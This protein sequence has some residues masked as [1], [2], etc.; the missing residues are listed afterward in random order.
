MEQTGQNRSQWNESDNKADDPRPFGMLRDRL[1]R[2]LTDL[3]ISVTDRCNF[4][5]TYCMPREVFGSNFAFLPHQ[6][7]LTF[8]EITR[9]AAIFAAHGVRKIRL[10]GGEPLLRKDLTKL[11]A[12]LAQ[13]EGLEDLALTTNGSL[14]SPANARALK[15][16]GLQRVTISLD[17]LDDEVF[18]AMND[19]RFPVSKVLH[20]IE[21][22]HDA[23]LTPVKVNMVVKKGV[24][25]QSILAMADYFRETGHVLRFIEFMDVGTTNGW[26][27]DQV[28]SAAQ[29]LATLE[30]HWPL[31]PMDP[32]P[33]QVAT[34]Y[35]YKDGKGEIGIIASVTKAF[36]SDCSRARISSEG[37]LYTCLFGARGHDFREQLRSQ[38]SDQEIGHF[39]R[40]VWGGRDDRYSELRSENTRGLQKIE[41]SHIGG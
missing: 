27:L 11:I 31:E 34:R 5:C 9:L 6:E 25:D 7:L 29:I 15:G 35:R 30:E 4:R 21:A 1:G 33:G 12:M 32:K 13:V 8:E 23:G 19:V 40:A 10:T 22:A 14:L 41:M 17:S 36:C 20:A 26:K 16:A 39:L 3:R 38:R 28:V 18:M 2:P 37:L 24:N